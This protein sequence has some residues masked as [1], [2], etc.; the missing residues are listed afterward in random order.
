[1]QFEGKGEHFFRSTLVQT[2]L[3]GIF[4]AWVIWARQRPRADQTVVFDWKTAAGTSSSGPR[5]LLADLRALNVR[6]GPRPAHR[7]ACRA[8]AG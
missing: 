5:T 6:A 7:R 2:P 3:Y 8:N 1:M 4:S